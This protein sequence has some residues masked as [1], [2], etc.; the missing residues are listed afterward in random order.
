[1]LWIDP[2]ERP[3]DA[4]NVRMLAPPSYAL[5][6][7]VMSSSLAFVNFFIGTSPRDSSPDAYPA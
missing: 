4:T 3:V 7:S 1:M 5:F 6:N 2:Y